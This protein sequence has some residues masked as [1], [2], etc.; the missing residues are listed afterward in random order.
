[1]VDLDILRKKGL[2]QEN[3]QKW[4]S[5]DPAILPG[6]IETD[7]DKDTGAKEKRQN[8]INRIRG[9]IQEGTDRNFKD[10]TVYHAL[11][12]AWN[13]PLQQI[14]P[15]LME[16]FLGANPEESQ[17]VQKLNEWG[18]KDLL[19]PAMDD[20]GT[21]TDKK[22]LNIPI[23]FRVMVPL[24]Q[25]YVKI[26][27]AKIMNDRRLLPFFKFA[28]I[29]STTELQTRCD[30]IT[31]RVQVMT[32]QYGYYD[33]LKQG[34]LKMLLYGKAFQFVR[35]E[36][37][38]EETWKSADALDV[39]E[40]SAVTDTEEEE[41]QPDEGENEEGENPTTIPAKKTKKPINLGDNIKVTSKEGLRYFHP[42]PTRVYYD[43]AHGPHT[44]NSD[45]GCE[46]VGHWRVQRYRDISQNPTFW[47]RDKI[48]FG[49]TSIIATNSI[50]FQ[51]VY[52]GCALNIPTWQPAKDGSNPSTSAGDQDREKA[53]SDQFYTASHLDQGV[54]TTEHFEKLIPIDN[55]LGDYDCPVW[56]RFVV[57][58]DG[59]TIL[60]ACPLPY[61]PTTYY[62]YDADE[63]R[64]LNASLALEVLPFQDQFSNVLTQILLTCRQNLAN[65]AMVD[66]DVLE[67]EQ[68]KKIE[69][70]GERL[71]RRI[72]IFSFSGKKVTR[73]GSRMVDILHNFNLPKGNVAE[74]ISVLK[75]ILDVLERVL[76][77]SSHEVAQAASHEQTREEVK[78]IAQSTSTRLLFTATPVDIARDSWKRQL[79]YGLMAYGDPHF[80]VQIPSETPL[81]KEQLKKMGFTYSEHHNYLPTDRYKT[82]KVSKKDTAIDIWFLTA[83]RDGEDRVN[84]QQTAVAM[85]QFAQQLLTNP[86]TAQAVGADQFI[87]IANRIAQLA[88]LPRDFKIRNMM[89][90]MTPEEQKADAAKQLQQVVDTVLQQLQPILMKQMEP[91]LAATK[92]NSETIMSIMQHLMPGFRGMLPPVAPGDVPQ[93]ND[94]TSPSPALVNGNGRT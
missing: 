13:T 22:T 11:D 15:T 54:V 20:K 72:N 10:Y 43:I 67:Q 32:D 40:N 78:N 6:H 46:F 75:T 63:S 55:G 14:S 8:L 16:E 34:V 28:P 45:S 76:V 81:T 24:V 37:H 65:F 68:I 69:N 89:P 71:L 61:T 51:T 86:M 50:F 35:E 5:G 38:C 88:G 44:L 25:A 77:M 94:T 92:Q 1:M 23:F 90:Q 49:R 2:T 18:L 29:K 41:Q 39:I 56:M 9:R 17:V 85:A 59:A 53:L 52:G 33:V 42:H 48:S 19:V 3:L 66:K 82:V 62:G 73:G 47:N 91:L 60:Y 93:L 70:L 79:Y 27:W 87:D 83:T 30:A 57:A 31:D 36:W 74:L 84:D 4:L 26:R 64:L 58:G 80:Y 12:K 21:P 7:V